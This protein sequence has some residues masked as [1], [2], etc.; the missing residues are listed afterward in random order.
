MD[1]K[2]SEEYKHLLD[3]YKVYYDKSNGY[4]KA[5]KK[6]KMTYLHRLIM[7]AKKGELVDHINRIKTDNRI[8]NLRI[9]TK[10]Q[11]NYNR[12]VKSKYGRGV[13]FDKNGD[14]FR[15]CIS[16]NNKTL[17]LGSF[18][19]HGEARAAY[20][21]KAKEVHGDLAILNFQFK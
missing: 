2:I 3:E 6:G 11:N 4:F 7:N 8:S 15:A 5:Y 18:K 1:L 19:T 20:N 9:V 21:K 14:R 12:G 13:Y 17:K 16:V 10:T